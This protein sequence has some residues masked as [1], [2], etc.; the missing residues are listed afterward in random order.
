MAYGLLSDPDMVDD[1][2]GTNVPRGILGYLP[3]DNAPLF[4]QSGM[5]PTPPSSFPLMLPAV[6]VPYPNSGDYWGAANPWGANNWGAA[7]PP[8]ANTSAANTWAAPNAAAGPWPGQYLAPV[9]AAPDWG[10]VPT[11]P[12]ANPAEVFAA[13]QPLSWNDVA[14]NPSGDY[15][16]DLSSDPLFLRSGLV[17]TPPTGRRGPDLNT[18]TPAEIYTYRMQQGVR[19]TFGRGDPRDTE[20]AIRAAAVS[21]LDPFGIPS[22]LVGQLSPEAKDMIRAQYENNPVAATIGGL[23]TP[24]PRAVVGV[25]EAL[26]KAMPKTM[27]VGLGLGGLATSSDEAEGAGRLSMRKAARMRRADVEGYWRNVPLESGRAPVNEEIVLPAVNVHG[28]VFTDP[29]WHTG[30]LFRAQHELGIPIDKM[31]LVPGY[32]GFTTNGK[33]FVHRREAN[34]IA[35]RRG[36]GETVGDNARNHGLSSEDV[37]LARDDF[38]APSEVRTAATAPGLPGGQGV[39]SWIISE[40]EAARLPRRSL[41]PASPEAP[42]ERVLTWHRSERPTEVNAHN[43]K[44]EEIH[45]KLQDA[46]KDNYDA[47]TL[48]NYRAPSGRTGDVLVVRDLE[49][50]RDPK[51]KFD[52]AH[53]NWWDVMAGLAGAGLLGPSFVGASRPTTDQ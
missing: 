47:V 31:K 16:R 42:G 36:F 7:N 37:M 10:Q 18:M 26:A 49:Q 43:L 28:R 44:E 11:T 27:A 12:T 34:D 33:R 29:I 17:P 1:V 15:P 5:A 51:A 50:L 19:P 22:W 24:T 6:P 13:P 48:R 30:A 14:A 45:D 53:R 2:D 23:A 40:P 38:V 21:A 9:P 39:W 3:D 32:D 52:P 35:S 20:A 4:L 46:W 25:V 8:A 41:P